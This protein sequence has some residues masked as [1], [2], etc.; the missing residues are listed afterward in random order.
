MLEPVDGTAK[1]CPFLQNMFKTVRQKKNS[2]KAFLSDKRFILNVIVWSLN[3]KLVLKCIFRCS[4]WNQHSSL[5]AKMQKKFGLV[6][7]F[8]KWKTGFFQ[9]SFQ[10]ILER[11]ELKGY[12]ATQPPSLCKLLI[13]KDVNMLEVRWNSVTQQF[14]DYFNLVVCISLVI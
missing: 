5:H 2:L 9:K 11:R 10:N 8:S 7:R 6:K 13:L 4:V 1:T 14:C 3:H 12:S